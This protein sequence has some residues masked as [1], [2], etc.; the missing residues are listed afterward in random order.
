VLTKGDK[1]DDAMLC[2]S[3]KTYAL[4]L[5]QTT[6]SFKLLLLPQHMLDILLQLLLVRLPPLATL[7]PAPPALALLLL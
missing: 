3:N 1:G 6:S 5:V 2:T 7:P 4:T